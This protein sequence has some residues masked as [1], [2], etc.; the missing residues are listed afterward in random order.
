MAGEIKF[1]GYEGELL[2][3][4]GSYMRAPGV[5][6]GKP[7]FKKIDSGNQSVMIYYWDERDG[8]QLRGWWVAPEVGGSNVWA[9][10]TATSNM[11]PHSGWRVPWHGDVNKKVTLSKCTGAEKRPGEAVGGA[12][13]KMQK[14]TPAYQNPNN[15]NMAPLGGAQAQ[16][17]QQQCGGAQPPMGS[18]PAQGGAWNAPGGYTNAQQTQGV[19]AGFQA[20][21]GQAGPTKLAQTRIVNPSNSAPGSIDQMEAQRQMNEAKRLEQEEKRKQVMEQTRQERKLSESVNGSVLA[22]S[23]AERSFIRVK[24]SQAAGQLFAMDVMKPA[25]LA[26]FSAEIEKGLK[27]A[28]AS[29]GSA[30]TLHTRKIQELEQSALM[31]SKTVDSLRQQLGEARDK[32]DSALKETQEFS[33]KVSQRQRDLWSK[34]VG[35]LVEKSLDDLGEAENGV[36]HLK[37]QSALLSSEIA[38]HLSPQEAIEAADV[39]HE[40]AV[41]AEEKIT[42]GR[43]SMHR[44]RTEVMTAINFF[45]QSNAVMGVSDEKQ[46]DPLNLA[47]KKKRIE[48]CLAKFPTLLAEVQKIRNLAV[49]IGNRARQA[50][51]LRK[52]QEQKEAQKRRQERRAKW[53]KQLIQDLG[54]EVTLC[55]DVLQRTEELRQKGAEKERIKEEFDTLKSHLERAQRTFEDFKQ[56]RD[57]IQQTSAE[58]DRWGQRI[59]ELEGILKKEMGTALA[60]PE[61]AAEIPGNLCVAGILMKYMEAE[62]KSGDELWKEVVNIKGGGKEEKPNTVSWYKLLEWTKRR[63]DYFGENN[64]DKHLGVELPPATD[65]NAGTAKVSIMQSHLKE[66]FEEMDLPLGPVGSANRSGQ[67]SEL[68]FTTAY[69]KFFMYRHPSSSAGAASSNEPSGLLSDLCLTA[70]ASDLD[71]P[72]KWPT[73]EDR[74]IVEMYGPLEYATPGD[75]SRVRMAVKLVDA[76]GAEQI[77][78]VTYFTNGRCQ[79]QEVTTLQCV[80]ETVI[81]TGAELKAIKTVRRARKDEFFRMLDLSPVNCRP[82]VRVYVQALSDGKA[83]FVTVSNAA[84]TFLKPAEVPKAPSEEEVA[85]TVPVLG[86]VRVSMYEAVLVLDDK[87]WRSAFLVQDLGMEDGVTES[88]TKMKVAW[89]SD[90][91]LA[92]VDLDNVR[93]SYD[94]KKKVVLSSITK[95]YLQKVAT[96]HVKEILESCDVPELPPEGLGDEETIAL[97]NETLELGLECQKTLNNVKSYLQKREI[98]FLVLGDP[99]VFREHQEEFNR[100]QNDLNNVRLKAKDM[101]DNAQEALEKQ[102]KEK[103]KKIYEEQLQRAREEEAGIMSELNTLIDQ[104]KVFSKQLGQ[105]LDKAE[106][107]AEQ[108]VSED[109]AD[110]KDMD[111]IIGDIQ[112]SLDETNKRIKACQDF[113]LEKG[114]THPPLK[115]KLNAVASEL[116]SLTVFDEVSAEERLDRTKKA[117][118]STLFEKYQSTIAEYLVSQKQ[119]AKKLFEELTKT[120][121]SP[122]DGKPVLLEPST[123]KG[124]WATSFDLE[125]MTLEQFE[126]FCGC[127]YVLTTPVTM[128]SAQ[129]ITGGAIVRK[130]AALT[131]VQMSGDSIID[132]ETMNSRRKAKVVSR[133]AAPLEEDDE[134]STS[135]EATDGWVTIYDRSNNCSN[136]KPFAIPGI[137][138]PVTVVKDT[139]LTAQSE[140]AQAEDKKFTVLRRIKAGEKVAIT[141]LPNLVDGTNMVRAPICCASDSKRGWMTVFDPTWKN[142]YLELI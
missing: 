55:V 41:K 67:I 110:V 104:A 139:V 13:T 69:R 113:V 71:D 123:L 1:E 43:D 47:D 95:E 10:S 61:A 137:T 97:A 138:S 87:D 54:S 117:A 106:E 98:R 53:N 141:G 91:T 65:P 126:L 15:P 114:T 112:H 39:S 107:P 29:L 84:N 118:L 79:L 32:L 4:N 42:E 12:A 14:T 57:T 140:I 120:Q 52:K 127:Y 23:N 88:T 50:E 3:L 94:Q 74:T 46:A 63:A 22:A 115:P 27:A 33:D 90:E 20:Q 44:R 6:H 75:K 128:T 30:M 136:V 100:M 24:D 133:L 58:I 116:P 80:S 70:E 73:L 19:G 119:T 72:Q 76:N 25:D 131:I 82:M 99:S 77:G 38:E 78:H 48:E 36:E 93:C 89:E 40:A 8:V 51:A 18:P 81:T 37:D 92:T 66:A 31:N 122:M 7:T 85:R 134:A 111:A 26:R 34:M 105:N 142:C 103:E 9:M 121:D 35:D 96:S 135:D 5:N 68:M 45:R 108:Q 101:L 129:T 21:A 130:L 56:K 16:Q 132:N 60:R 125:P 83:G 28:Q 86:A 102:L 17:Q 109:P 59:E 64:L 62:G 124:K 2:D 11:P 49:H